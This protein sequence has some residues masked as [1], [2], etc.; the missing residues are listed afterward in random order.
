MYRSQCRA[1]FPGEAFRS[2]SQLFHAAGGAS[3][4]RVYKR[5]QRALPDGP[6]HRGHQE[7]QLGPDSRGKRA[8]DHELRFQPGAGLRVAR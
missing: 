8:E 5:A 7:G 6:C 4:M 2:R 1:H 3:Q